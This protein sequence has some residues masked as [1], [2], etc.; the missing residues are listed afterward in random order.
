MIKECLGKVFIGFGCMLILV[1]LFLRGYTKYRKDKL[2]K[3]Y[4]QYVLS[5]QQEGLEKVEQKKAIGVKVIEEQEETSEVRQKEELSEVIA[6]EKAIGLLEISKIDLQV[7]LC[8][9]VEESVLKYAVGH[10]KDTALPGE[11]GNCGIIGHRNYTYGEFFNRLDEMEIGDIISIKRDVETLVYEVYE[12]EVVKPEQV[13]VLDQTED[14]QVTLITCT[15]MRS[16]TH[17]LVVKG[18]RVY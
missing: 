1:A 9:G 14:E 18:K 15:P 10:F 12:I 8:E 16:G 5:M 6:D 7:A 4:S 13:E 3:Q 2:V 17:R 11:K